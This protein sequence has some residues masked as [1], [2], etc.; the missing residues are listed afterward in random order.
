LKIGATGSFGMMGWQKVDLGESWELA[1][2][3]CL[4][5][6]DVKRDELEDKFVGHVSFGTNSADKPSTPKSPKLSRAGKSTRS[7]AQM[8]ALSL[9]GDK[10]LLND[11]MRKDWISGKGEVASH[12]R[13]Q[14]ETEERV[15]R[16]EK[17]MGEL[18][19]EHEKDEA[20][21]R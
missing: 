14:G 20:K 10:Y 16:L 1:E 4:L 5:A 15:G 13:L 18:R 21:F 17:E 2:K 3:E 8:Q 6:M 19:Y 9:K 7:I 12:F 11:T